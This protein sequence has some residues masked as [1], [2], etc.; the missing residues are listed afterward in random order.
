MA[1]VQQA[2][3]LFILKGGREI[4]KVQGS[5]QVFDRIMQVSGS[6]GILADHQVIQLAGR[7]MLEYSADQKGGRTALQV[8]TPDSLG[9]GQYKL[10]R[11]LKKAGGMQK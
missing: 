2:I 8:L 9:M 6:F 5:C 10:L 7:I 4:E 3:I 1:A 11:Q